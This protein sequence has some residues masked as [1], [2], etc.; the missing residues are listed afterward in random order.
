MQGIF[1]CLEEMPGSPNDLAFLAKQVAKSAG[2]Q[3]RLYQWCGTED[4]LYGQN[5]AFRRLAKK[6]GLALSYSEGPGGHEWVHWDAQIQK[7]IE[8]MLGVSQA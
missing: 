2:P 5:V 1:G 8:W 7:V 3:P 4:F 6:L